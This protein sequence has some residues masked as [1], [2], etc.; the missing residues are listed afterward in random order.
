M[1]LEGGLPCAKVIIDRGTELK[2]RLECMEALGYLFKD[3]LEADPTN[4]ALGHLDAAK[5]E[6]DKALK[7]LNESLGL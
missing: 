7:V 3:Q 6:I 4:T 2:A 1:A 5:E